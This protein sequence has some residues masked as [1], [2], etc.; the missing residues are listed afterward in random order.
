MSLT[1]YCLCVGI[2]YATA[3]LL[4]G[5]GVGHSFLTAGLRCE[6][7]NHEAIEASMKKLKSSG[8]MPSLDFL[9]EPLLDWHLQ[10]FLNGGDD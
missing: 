7:L 8:H 3:A 9:Q 2:T 5:I 4:G 10:S 1:V 6:E